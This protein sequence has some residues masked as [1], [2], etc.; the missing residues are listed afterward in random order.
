M[1]LPQELQQYTANPTRFGNSPVHASIAKSLV[2][3]VDNFL[4]SSALSIRAAQ[5]GWVLSHPRNPAR[6]MIRVHV[7]WCWLLYVQS[8]AIEPL[9]LFIISHTLVA[10]EGSGDG[11]FS[12]T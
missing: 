1:W 12:V 5:Q 2:G 11:T 4:G 7:S 8:I 3:W 6:I 10:P 9:T